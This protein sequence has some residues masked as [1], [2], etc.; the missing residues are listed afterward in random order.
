MVP[1]WHLSSP[2]PP[3]LQNP[4]AGTPWARKGVRRILEGRHASTLGFSILLENRD[5]NYLSLQVAPNPEKS[6]VS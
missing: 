5:T 6:Q 1:W 3:L 4:L 2:L